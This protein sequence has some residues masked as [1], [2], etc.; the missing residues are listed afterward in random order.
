MLP[1]LLYSCLG[2]KIGKGTS[3]QSVLAELEAMRGC[4][5]VVVKR[6]EGSGQA[7]GGESPELIVH[8]HLACC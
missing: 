1:P 3:S 5:I 4:G 7:I 6:A 8:R 2:A